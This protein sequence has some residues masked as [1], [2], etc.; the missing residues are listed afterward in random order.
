MGAET[1]VRATIQDSSEVAPS[2]LKPSRRSSSPPSRQMRPAREAMAAADSANS[3]MIRSV[4]SLA[5]S[6]ALIGVVVGV[7]AGAV[8]VAVGPI[9]G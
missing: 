8:A 1:P 6:P 3:S 2:T 9:G 7:A 5:T 4:D